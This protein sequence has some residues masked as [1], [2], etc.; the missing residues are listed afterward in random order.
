[1][2]REIIGNHHAVYDMSDGQNKPL[3]GPQIKF[4]EEFDFLQIR[5]LGL[6]GLETKPQL[7]QHEEEDLQ[8]TEV[9]ENSSLI[10]M[11]SSNYANRAKMIR[12]T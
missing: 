10:K 3:K 8:A 9:D 12:E 2:I 1:M 5:Q 11:R 6:P 4:S 7:N